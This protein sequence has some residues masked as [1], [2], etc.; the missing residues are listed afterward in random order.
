MIRLELR[1]PEQFPKKYEK[2]ILRA[3][4]QCSV[5]R[6]LLDPPAVETDLA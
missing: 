3:V 1:L 2:A 4:D 5:R 6:C